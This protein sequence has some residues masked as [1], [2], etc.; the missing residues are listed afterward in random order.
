MRFSYKLSD[1]IHILAFLDIYR[2]GDLSSKMIAASIGANASVVRNL[3]SELRESG[4][5][6]TRQ[7]AVTPMLAKSPS[8][9][10][11]YDVYI[12]IS[13][14]HNL[15]HIDPKTNPDCIVGGNIQQTLNGIYSEIETTAYDRMKS[16]SISDVIKD[17]LVLQQYK[18][19]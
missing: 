14:D 18:T 16:I 9:I 2:D 17:I 1:A 11:L 7:G 15:L 19:K 13:I 8:E 4:F 10:S 5:I 6:T 3:M 12:A